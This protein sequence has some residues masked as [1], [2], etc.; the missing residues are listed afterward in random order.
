MNKR[1]SVI[2]EV[3]AGI[4]AATSSPIAAIPGIRPIFIVLPL[5]A[6]GIFLFFAGYYAGK[7]ENKQ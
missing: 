4:S 2:F 6:M 7:A 3:L 1:K 5:V